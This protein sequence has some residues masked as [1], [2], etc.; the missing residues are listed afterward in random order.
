[1]RRVIFFDLETTGTD[2][3]VD[4]ICEFAFLD[5]PDSLVERVN[6]GVPIPAEATAVHGIS[7]A[8]VADS[9]PFV[10][11][12]PT[13]Q[14]L[15]HDAVLCGF[16]SRRFDTVLLHNEL[17]R[18]GEEGLPLDSVG[19][20]MQPEIDLYELWLRHE[21]RK[22][23]TAAKRFG[24]IELGEDAHAADADTR[25]LP[26]TLAGMCEAFGLDAENIEQLCALS[27]PDGAI[28][29]D[30]KFVKKD[31]VV[32]FNFGNRRGEPADSDLGL[33][34]WVLRKDF[35][36]ETKAVALAIYRHATRRSA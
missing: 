7:D 35:N 27:V 31:G 13:I 18:A 24:G 34:E 17:L 3:Y 14:A 16:N 21:N 28:D 30:G 1:M 23:V 20:I 29:R 4:R 22:L 36:Q 2:P 32:C 12:A 25:V 8:D 6:P 11:W 33:L 5:G 19:R 26:A 10:Y 9:H 15:V